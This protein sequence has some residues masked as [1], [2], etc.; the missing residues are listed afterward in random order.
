MWEGKMK[1][2]KLQGKCLILSDFLR[3]TE[4]W[5]DGTIR[6]LGGVGGLVVTGEE[7]DGEWEED[8]A[9]KGGI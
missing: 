1:S 6:D 8:E 9:W 2:W 7:D 5:K 3:G 4:V